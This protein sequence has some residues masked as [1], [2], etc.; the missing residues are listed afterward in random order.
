MRLDT[1]F[2]KSVKA[3]KII[4]RD[5]DFAGVVCI[6]QKVRHVGSFFREIRNYEVVKVKVSHLRLTKVG[7]PEAIPVLSHR[8]RRWHFHV[9]VQSNG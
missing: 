8:R 5:S 4:F 6:M 2:P 7:F 1:R 9:P 3:T